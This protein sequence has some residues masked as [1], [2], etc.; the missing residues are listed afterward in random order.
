MSFISGS[1]HHDFR[2]VNSILPR[3]TSVCQSHLLPCTSKVS[4]SLYRFSNLFLQEFFDF[5]AGTKIDL[6][7]IAFA[8]YRLRLFPFLLFYERWHIPASAPTDEK[9]SRTMFSILHVQRINT[10]LHDGKVDVSFLCLCGEG[11]TER[12]SVDIPSVPSSFED[13]HYLIIF[14]VL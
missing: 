9:P 6:I 5:F 2:T 13:N 3:S 14:L 8:L 10:F 7:N 11:D 1:G 12:N 4:I